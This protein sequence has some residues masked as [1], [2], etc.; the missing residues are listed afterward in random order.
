[1]EFVRGVFPM[2]P[3]RIQRRHF[4]AGLFSAFAA[5]A[6]VRV[7]NI[8]P[9]RALSPEPSDPLVCGVR[10]QTF[11]FGNP[12]PETGFCTGSIGPESGRGVLKPLS[13][14]VSRIERHGQFW[15]DIY[16]KPIDPRS[17]SPG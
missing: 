12:Y 15:P 2:T 4:L 16:W 3:V 8:M 9:V 11:P 17:P 7:E 6:I 5:P 14:F 13:H 1:M 10:W